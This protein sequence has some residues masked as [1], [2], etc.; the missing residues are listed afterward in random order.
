MSDAG[1]A[2]ELG[3]PGRR[4]GGQDGV[5][6]GQVHAAPPPHPRRLLQQ[7][8]GLRR[9]SA[10]GQ[11]GAGPRVV[12]CGEEEGELHMS[13]ASVLLMSHLFQY[14]WQDRAYELIQ[15]SFKCPWQ[16]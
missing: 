10:Q 12:R 3:R 5:R 14:L 15:K 11:E 7:A 16:V 6:L 8:R 2:A 13:S 4:G 1:D 9:G